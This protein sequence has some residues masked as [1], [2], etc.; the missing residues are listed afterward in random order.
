MISPYVV[1]ARLACHLDAVASQNGSGL[2]ATGTAIQRRMGP[3]IFACAGV[4]IGITNVQAAPPRPNC[5]PDPRYAVDAAIA[6]TCA[7]EFNSDG[8]TLNPVAD[9]VAQTMSL[10]AALLWQSF[11]DLAP[12]ITFQI[13]GGLG[14]TTAVFTA[15]EFDLPICSYPQT[16]TLEVTP[17][18]AGV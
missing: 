4:S 8:Q 3:N 15:G 17:A 10:D 11:A 16:Q 2:P 18:M 5:A 12:L 9:M 1:A 6:R 13:T 14:I 7:V